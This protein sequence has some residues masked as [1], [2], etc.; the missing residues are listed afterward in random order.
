MNTQHILNAINK[1][2]SGTHF[3]YHSEDN[4]L[5]ALLMELETRNASKMAELQ[6][7]VDRLKELNVALAYGAKV[8]ATRDH[9]PVLSYAKLDDLRAVALNV[10]KEKGLVT[11]DTLRVAYANATRFMGL[12]QADVGPYLP[13]VFRDKRFKKIG[14]LRSTFP[15][16][17]G[18]FINVWT[19]TA[20]V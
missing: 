6:E 14:F 9:F 7:S 11:A 10:A 13:Y 8:N 18:R 20:A 15:A 12:P 5:V 4:V 1:V 2:R 19:H 16:N 17:K 3:Y